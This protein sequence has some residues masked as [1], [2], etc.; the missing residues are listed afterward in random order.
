MPCLLA[1]WFLEVPTNVSTQS[2]RSYQ[3]EL[4]DAVPS[5]LKTPLYCR[6]FENDGDRGNTRC[7]QLCFG[8]PAVVDD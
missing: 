4:H 5:H 1:L 8:N 3:G 2:T 7:I 6:V